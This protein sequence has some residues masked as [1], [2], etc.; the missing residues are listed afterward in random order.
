MNWVGRDA[1]D[2][3]VDAVPR[4]S[5]DT[6][7]VPSGTDPAWRRARP[8]GSVVAV[9]CLLIPGPVTVRYTV[10]CGSGVLATVRVRTALIAAAGLGE[11]ASV[12][13]T[14]VMLN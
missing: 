3:K 11:T 1:V 10:C 6:V 2:K 14:L 5:A 9:T 8:W 12:V 4:N 13:G 7:Y